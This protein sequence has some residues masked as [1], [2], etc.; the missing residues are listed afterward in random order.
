M[1]QGKTT[2]IQFIYHS[3]GDKDRWLQNKGPEGRW[4]NGLGNEECGIRSAHCQHGIIAKAPVKQGRIG[5]KQKLSRIEAKTLFR[6]PRT[7]R[8]KTIPLAWFGRTTCC[9]VDIALTVHRNALFPFVMEQAE[10][11]PAGIA[12]TYGELC[13]ACNGMRPQA[14]AHFAPAVK[15]CPSRLSINLA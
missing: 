13:S 4:D 2:D 9:E 12:R 6:R 10:V 15:L 11:N 8:T 14:S 3:P 5:I 1:I 7:I